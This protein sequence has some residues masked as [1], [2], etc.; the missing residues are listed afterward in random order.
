MPDRT[1]LMIP[2]ASIEVWTQNIFFTLS[3]I[4]REH[5]NFFVCRQI[6]SLSKAKLKDVSLLINL[7]PS[8]F[9]DGELKTPSHTI[10]AQSNFGSGSSFRPGLDLL[11]PESL[12]QEKEPY[13]ITDLFPLKREFL[14]AT[15][16]EKPSAFIAVRVNDLKISILQNDL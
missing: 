13:L 12:E 15:V 3:S 11:I 4:E 14:I 16:D 7:L 10:V 6:P 1:F 9:N 2:N 5:N 8:D